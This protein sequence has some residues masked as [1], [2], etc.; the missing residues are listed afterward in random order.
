[1]DSL[2]W[3]ATL[4]GLGLC[5]PLVLI[6]GAWSVRAW[7]E[8][9]LTRLQFREWQA[10]QRAELDRRD[11][12]LRMRASDRPT[13]APA[14]WEGWR[15]FRVREIRRETALANSVWLEPVDGLPVAPFRPGQYLTI[16]LSAG[17]NDKPQVR[18]YSLSGPIAEQAYQ[19]T[20]KRVQRDPTKPEQTS[21]SQWI[22]SGMMAGDV[23]EARA[24]GGDFVLVEDSDA[25]LVLL[26]AGIGI[27]PLIAMID[28]LTESGS[29]RQVVLFYG[30]RN[31]ED[32]VFRTA[33]E[34][35][36]RRNPRLAIINVYSDPRSEDIEGRSFHVR[37]QIN[38][39]LVRRI[40][41]HQKFQFYLC[42]PPGF[43]ASLY[44]GLRGWGVPEERIFREAF[45]PASI[46]RKT[47]PLAAP[48]A[49]PGGKPAEIAK[50]SFA[51]SHR[52][53]GLE[54]AELSILELAESLSIEI[55][56]GCRA[57]SCG[58]CAIRL[59]RGKIRYDDPP[60]AQ[61][62]PG[63]CLACIAKPEGSVEVQ[64]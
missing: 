32:H 49:S 45:G 21:V 15:R 62:D 56:S 27:T 47:P 36:A 60:A 35:Y 24:P 12:S 22:H 3:I 39:E 20:V 55:N 51:T 43:M 61:V 59:L 10:R 31:G 44:E 19:L 7:Q 48:Y 38:M 40:L 52:E 8:A 25:P 5:L 34:G 4:I 37:G 17:R 9:R 30:N 29:A 6:L 23:V 53:A 58:S 14:T 57:G 54:S 2:A 13:A 18:C 63:Y 28:R 26:A 46:A 42:G 11:G 41:P 50:V 1:M 64:A 16:R 33:L